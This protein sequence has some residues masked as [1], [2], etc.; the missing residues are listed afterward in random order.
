MHHQEVV[1]NDEEWDDNEDDYQPNAD[2]EK[3]F[4]DDDK[5]E[6]WHQQAVQ[7]IKTYFENRSFHC[8]GPI[9]HSQ[10][11]SIKNVELVRDGDFDRGILAF[12]DILGQK[13]K[14]K[15]DIELLVAI[16]HEMRRSFI[17][18]EFHSGM[19]LLHLRYCLGYN[20]PD[21]VFTD[22]KMDAEELLKR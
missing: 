3:S 14:S 22:T 4:F 1:L 10:L 2:E 11:F 18:K 21:W 6:M 5:T 13:A 19:A 12:H 8:G 15:T 20:L 16:M 9:P 17:R 7:Q